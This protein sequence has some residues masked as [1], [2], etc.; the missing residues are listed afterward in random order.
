MASMTVTTRLVISSRGVEWLARLE[1][2]TAN[3]CNHNCRSEIARSNRG[4]VRDELSGATLNA[5]CLRVSTG[6]YTEG[7]G[8]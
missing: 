4:G 2:K 1:S 3:D 7:D 5:S 6:V 8:F